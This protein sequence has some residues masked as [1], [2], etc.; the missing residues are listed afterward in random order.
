MKGN[1][2]TDWAKIQTGR[3]EDL[4]LIILFSGYQGQLSGQESDG[5][6]YYP[7]TNGQSN[8]SSPRKPQDKPANRSL[9]ASL[10]SARP[11]H[12]RQLDLSPRSTSM[13]E[14]SRDNSSSDEEKKKCV[15]T[16]TH[17]SLTAEISRLSV[18]NSR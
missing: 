14:Q 15:E 1:F 9:N 13:T 10:L 12:Q 3:L 2:N 6:T 7:K 5:G 8:E 11:N 17:P 16:R 4:L 18:E